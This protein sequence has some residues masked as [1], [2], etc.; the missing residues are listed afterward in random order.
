MAAKVKMLT[1]LQEIRAFAQITSRRPVPR[2]PGLFL[3]QV[4]PRGNHATVRRR[5]LSITIDPPIQPDIPL[6]VKI[7]H[8]KQSPDTAAPAP[9]P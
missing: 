7:H 2:S 5:R 4:G 9:A 1:L 6:E 8:V 3:A